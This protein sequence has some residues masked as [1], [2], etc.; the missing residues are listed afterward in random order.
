MV[1][2]MNIYYQWIPGCYSHMACDKYTKDELES[3]WVDSFHKVFDKIEE[4]HIGVLPIENSYAGS[5]HTNL[6]K[7][8]TWKYEII[9]DLYLPI[10]HC[11]LANNDDIDN[12]EK[13]YSH[14]QALMQCEKFIEKNDMA[15]E[16]YKDTAGSA[17]FVKDSG[18]SNIASISSSLAAD[19]YDLN[20][21]K[22]NIQ[23]QDGNTTR[24]FVVKQ[25]WL[26]D[27]W[28]FDSLEIEKSNKKS[29]IFKTKHIPAAL[30][31]CLGA[32]STRG[33]NL[34]KIESLPA[35]GKPFEVLFWLDI[36]TGSSDE[37][38]EQALE[39]L[40]FFSKEVVVLGDY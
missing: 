30:Y 9:G 33:I 17:K 39:E 40:E 28:V 5:V 22:N 6:Y 29:L 12:I 11:L 15:Q 18:K 21:V 25:K 4:W 19:I 20:R 31:K 7:L 36:E 37:L 32:F 35:H 34:T 23:D 16:S 13:V 1:M 38:L 2:D 3:K 14:Y 27:D 10:N 26:D 24:F 8:G